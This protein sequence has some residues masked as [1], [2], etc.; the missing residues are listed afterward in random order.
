MVGAQFGREQALGAELAMLVIEVV[1]AFVREALHVLLGVF[2]VK[3]DLGLRKGVFA[4]NEV[5]SMKYRVVN[6]HEGPRAVIA[7]F[8]GKLG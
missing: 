8:L 6:F 7:L 1:Q 4:G 5:E 2:V 3:V